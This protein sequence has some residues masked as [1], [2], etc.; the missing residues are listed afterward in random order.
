M[1]NPGYVA[2][3][4]QSGLYKELSVV[5]NNIANMATSGYRREGV[6][7]AEAVRAAAVEGGSI[8]MSD[9][10]VRNTDYTE[11][12]A[13]QTGGAFDFAI[14]GPGFFRVET[15]DGERLTRG[16]SFSR[17]VAGELTTQDGLRVL[18]EGGAPIFAPPDA[19]IEVGPDGTMTAN[20][21]PFARL[22]VVAPVDPATLLRR[23]GVLFEATEGADPV[24]NPVVLQGYIENSNVDPVIELARM[25]EVQRAYELGQKFLDRE[26]ERIRAATRA[27]GA[28]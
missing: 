13:A 5:A 23:D 4:R 9:A 18:D 7:F 2:L 15:P 24:I 28:A 20:G 25:I 8:A 16:G 21:A 14:Q 22:G 10:R 6:I 12:A 19:Q 1:D 17:N 26:D 27:L 11:G 3:S